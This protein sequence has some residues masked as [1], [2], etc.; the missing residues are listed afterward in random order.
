MAAVEVERVFMWGWWIYWVV[1]CLR[2][3]YVWWARGILALAG[4]AGVKLFLRG[5]AI[6][7][8]RYSVGEW[9]E[10]M[11]CHILVRGEGGRCREPLCLSWVRAGVRGR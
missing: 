8:W 1:E 3:Q 7:T 4:G 2:Q 5:G 11:G 6:A 10:H 9:L